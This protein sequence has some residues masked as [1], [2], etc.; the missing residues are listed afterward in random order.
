MQSIM[1]DA[2]VSPVFKH[3]MAWK[4]YEKSMEQ[5]V[6]NKELLK[7]AADGI[8]GLMERLSKTLTQRL[9]IRWLIFSMHWAIRRLR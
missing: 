8:P 2:T 6:V 9:W 5:G 3:D 1:S 4:A 7:A